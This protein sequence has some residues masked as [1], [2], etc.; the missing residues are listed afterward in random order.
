MKA[1]ESINLAGKVNIQIQI[2][3]IMVV[4][5]TVLNPKLKAKV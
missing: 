5:N 1:Y 3:I 4:C 2:T